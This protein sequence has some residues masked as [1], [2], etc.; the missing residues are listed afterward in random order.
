MGTRIVVVGAGMVGTEMVEILRKRPRFAI[1][2]ITI[3]ARTERRMVIDD[4][5]YAVEVARPEGF[6]GAKFA[7]FAGTE[8]EAG[9]SKEFAKE[10]VRRGCIVIDNGSDF[11][12]DPDVP[13]IIPEV[14]PKALKG[15]CGLIASPNCSTIIML[16][17]LAPLHRINPIAKVYVT[18]LQAVS[19]SGT[20]GIRELEAQQRA[21]LQGSLFEREIYPHP[22]FGNVIPAIGSFVD[23]EHSSEELKMLY[24]TQKIL[25][26]K[27]PVYATCVR[28]P[29]MN[30]HSMN[31]VVEFQNKIHDHIFKKMCDTLVR[32][33]GVIV[34]D[35][36]DKGLYPLPL[37]ATGKDEVFV[38]RIRQRD[39]YTLEMFVSGDN[40]L[41]GAALNAVQIAELLF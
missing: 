35:E 7:F 1:E 28:V 16:M 14:N 32:S 11:R 21:I 22:I 25:G 41:K 24:E 3:L 37:L 38:G 23:N 18:T 5:I 34:Y 4:E 2:E 6:D 31:I 29:I 30:G 9:A 12:M 33:P 13:L 27:I 10:A 20:D 17:A 15:H 40:I 19:G 39:L 36:P 26:R 8:G